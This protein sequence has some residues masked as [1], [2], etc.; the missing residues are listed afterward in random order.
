MTMKQVV[1]VPQLELP[2]RDPARVDAVLGNRRRSVSDCEPIDFSQCGLAKAYPDLTEFLGQIREARLE[3]KSG[4]KI[5]PWGCMK[6]RRRAVR[7]F[8]NK[9][10]DVVPW[11]SGPTAADVRR[12][13]ATKDR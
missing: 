2:F 1:I 11:E 13:Y 6:P 9:I 12:A 4:G 5:A 3:Q 7:T 8:T 10:R